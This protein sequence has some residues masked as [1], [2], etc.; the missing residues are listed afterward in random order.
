MNRKTNG[1]FSTLITSNHRYLFHFTFASNLPCILREGLVPAPSHIYSVNRFLGEGIYF[2]DAIANAGLN[3]KS[4]NTVYILAC[5]VALGNAKQVEQQ[6]LNHD[7][8]L[9]WDDGFDSIYCLGQK[10]TSSRDAEEDLNGAKIY[11]GQLGERKTGDYGYSLYNE[12][13]IRN[14]QQVSVEYIIK[15]VK[16]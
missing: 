5:R 8:I 14:K 7:Q 4:L 11:C 15:L 13:V 10:F 1:D 2:W 6:Y 9:D 12:Y 16:E 3:Y